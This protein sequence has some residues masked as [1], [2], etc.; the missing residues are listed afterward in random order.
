MKLHILAMGSHPDDVELGCGGTIAKAVSEGKKVGIVD[1]TRG[2]LGTRGTPE[3]RLQEADAAGKILGIH[4]RENLG[5][6]DGFFQNNEENQLKVI[7]VIRKYQPDILICGAP[8]DRH[9]DHARSTLLIREAAFLAG[10]RSIKTQHQPW[11]PKRIFMFIQWK[12]LQPDFV[13]N[14]SGFLDKKIESCL[15]YSSQ[16][17]D[18]ESK[19]PATAISSENFKESI[20][21]RAS[22]WGRLIWKDA[23]EGFISDSLLGVESMDVFL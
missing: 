22:D 18:P 14:I 9:P 16:F 17:Y 10:L 23:A 19:E 12:N 5:M 8:E 13:V 4:A 2:E 21:Y 15:A 20:T 7:E 1:L 11:R 6:R 3:I